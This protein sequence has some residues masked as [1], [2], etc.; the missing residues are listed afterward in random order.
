MPESRT[1]SCGNCGAKYR[2]PANFRGAK[3]RCKACGGVIDIETQGLASTSTPKPAAKPA[4]PPSSAPAAKPKTAAAKPGRSAPRTAGRPAKAAGTGRGA[5]A[6]AGRRGARAGKEKEDRGARAPSRGG[7][8][9]AAPRGGR[10]RRGEAPEAK[11]KTPLILGIA[12]LVI[13]LGVAGFFVFS[14]N[15]AG[16]GASKTEDRV[17]AK[18][19]GKET[20]SPAGAESS[21]KEGT[22][23]ESSA[24]AKVAAAEGP[25][26]NTTGTAEGTAKEPKEGKPAEAAAKKP[27][28]TKKP[29]AAKKKK[30]KKKKPKWG[31]L[32]RPFDAKTLPELEFTADTTEEEK[33]EI[34]KL[35][36]KALDP[37][38]GIW[39]TRAI[40]KLT[41]MGRKAIPGILNALR[42]VDYMSQEGSEMAFLMNKTLEEILLGRNAGF[43]QVQGTPKPEVAWWN[44]ATVKAW[45]R[46]WR[47]VLGSGDEEVFKDFLKKRRENIRKSSG[48]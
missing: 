15:D 5:R 40:K 11:S 37:D 8:G 33:A 44:A 1:I 34:K 2:I 26:G 28:E 29:A 42:T 16:K 36:A 45:Q 18:D 43:V 10:G 3:A 38:A 21:S 20:G 39:G 30:K 4:L 47:D 22:K 41:E 35:V 9:R 31:E 13:V 25:G 7:R 24:A 17:A 19:T 32:H 12:G 6:G 46:F 14:G 48:R 23:P 27:A